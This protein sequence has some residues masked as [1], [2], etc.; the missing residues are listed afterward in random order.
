MNH[1]QTQTSKIPHDPDL[2]EATTFP[3]IVYSVPSHET[4]TEMSFVPGLPSGR[5]EIP[6]VG[7]LATLRPYNF[8]CKPPIEM[9]FKPKL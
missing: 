3:L 9:R 6:I 5:P 7:T 8:V 4:S 1:E 2:E